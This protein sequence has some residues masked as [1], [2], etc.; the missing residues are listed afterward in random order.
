MGEASRRWAGIANRFSH[1]F[2]NHVRLGSSLKAVSLTPCIT[3]W[4]YKCIYDR[5]IPSLRKDG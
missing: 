5:I 2:E 3:S 4:F 1:T